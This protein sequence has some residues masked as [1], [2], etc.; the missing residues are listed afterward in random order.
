MRERAEALLRAL[1]ARAD[2]LGLPLGDGPMV[3]LLRAVLANL[4]R[5]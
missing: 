3:S 4:E 2:R 1:E 5:R